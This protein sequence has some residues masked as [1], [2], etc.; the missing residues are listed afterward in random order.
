MDLRKKVRNKARVEGCIVEAQLVEEATNSTS[1]FF[2]SKVHSARNKAPRYDDRASTFL[3]CCDIEIF[4]QPGRC[5][6][7]RRM[8]DLST[9]E[10]KAAFLYILINIPE[11]EDFL[12]KFDEEQWMG[13]RHPTEQQ[14]SELRMNGWKAGRGSNIHY[15]PNLFDWFKSYFKSEHLWML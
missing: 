14:T 2:K 9:H 10:Y 7:P 5:F 13:T 15:G 6:C 8:R 12:K 1:L 3:P 11:M 4:Q